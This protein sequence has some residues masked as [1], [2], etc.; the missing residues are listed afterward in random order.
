MLKKEEVP[1]M[2]NYIL[3]KYDNI[4]LIEKRISYL[5]GAQ[6]RNKDRIKQAIQKQ[7]EIKTRHGTTEKWDTVSQI[8]KWREAR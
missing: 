1:I 3:E 8:R 6:L 5:L 7:D 4:E 2:Q